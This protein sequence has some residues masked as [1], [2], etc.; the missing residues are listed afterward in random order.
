MKSPIK[1]LIFD[2][3]GLLFDTEPTW[4]EAFIVFLENHGIEDNPEITNKMTGMGLRDALQI[5]QNKMGLVGDLDQLVSNYRKLFYE[6]FLTKQNVL[7]PGAKEILEK[8]KERQLIIALTS[9]G[10]AKAK[11]IE[12]LKLHKMYGYFSVIVSSDEVS[13]GK[14]A[15]DVYL[16][17]LSELGQKADFCLAFEDSPNGV[18]AAKA[19]EIRVYGVNSDEKIRNDLVS[20]GADRVFKNLSEIE[21]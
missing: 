17:A 20:A 4:D 21:L 9:G 5:M 15:P 1:A 6:I 18:V 12:I 14:P 11:L 16:E 8:A 13:L 3:D 19:A 7:M 2:F 10:H